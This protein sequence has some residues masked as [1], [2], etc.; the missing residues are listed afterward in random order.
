MQLIVASRDIGTSAKSEMFQ[1]QA[2]HSRLLTKYWQ[3]TAIEN[4]LRLYR[5]S[6]R[7][8]CCLC[9]SCVFEK[10]EVVPIIRLWRF[11]FSK[12]E[13]ATNGAKLPPR[14]AKAERAV[15]SRWR[16]GGANR[17]GAKVVPFVI[18]AITTRLHYFYHSPFLRMWAMSEA[19]SVRAKPREGLERSIHS[20]I[21]CSQHR[22]PRN[23]SRNQTTWRDEGRTSLDRWILESAAV[24]VPR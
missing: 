8:G 16:Q 9:R 4:T 17:R 14:G 11:P 3:N 10:P 2:L 13:T 15:A 23:A 1:K 20:A 19:L 12:A 21:V 6:P 22:P 18:G 24:V 7:S 5:P